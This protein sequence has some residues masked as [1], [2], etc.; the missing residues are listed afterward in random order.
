MS[1]SRSGII[2]DAIAW[3][4]DPLNW[5]GP[6]GIG[7]LTVEHLGMSG[8]AVLLGAGFALPL[9][10]WLGH[11]HR[12][13]QLTVLLSNV[14]RAMPTLA[15]LTLFASSAIGFGNRAVVIA[16]AIF[17]VP[18]I[19]TN[20]FTGML[21]VDADVRDAARGMGLGPWRMLWHVEVPLAL[22]VIAA[23]V[24]TAAVQVVA[25]VPLAALVA[26]GGLG[27]IINTGLSTLRYGQVLA[28]GVLVAVLSMSVEGLLAGGQRLLTPRFMTTRR[29]LERPA[30]APAAE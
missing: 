18:P 26:G 23:G 1:G 12:G 11:R 24:R 3:L 6:H 22:P 13:G 21:E 15:L 14:S 2:G 10:L 17:A 7:A 9:G 19:L 20:T 5:T 27:V 16:A 25:T 4:N 30:V 8:A 29:A 28:G